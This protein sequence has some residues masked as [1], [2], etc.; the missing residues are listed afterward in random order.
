MRS[1]RR[2]LSLVRWTWVLAGKGRTAGLLRGDELH[3]LDA[4]LVGVVEVELDFAVAAHLTFGAVGPFAVIAGQSDDSVRH[5]DDAEGEMI[6][7]PG[8]L[9]RWVGRVVE[10]VLEPVGAVGDL[11]ADPVVD[12]RLWT[13]V[14]VRTDAEDAFPERVFFRLTR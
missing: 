6:H 5:A 2:G 14:P 12:V 1:S 7:D 13:A 10:H 4:S 8:V 9:K 3:E 11:D